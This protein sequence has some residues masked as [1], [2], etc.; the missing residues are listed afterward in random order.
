[1]MEEGSRDGLRR[2]EWVWCPKEGEAMEV[3]WAGGQP[4]RSE[5][6]FLRGRKTECSHIIGKSGIFQNCFLKK[7]FIYSQERQRERGRDTGRGRSRLHA[8]SPMWD[9]ILG[10]QD[11]AL[12][13]GSAKPLSHPGC[14]QNCF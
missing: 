2:R 7:Y 10:L 9:S 5:M 13:E 6:T 8:G 11:Q 3:T 12:A 14:P 4:Q 1:M